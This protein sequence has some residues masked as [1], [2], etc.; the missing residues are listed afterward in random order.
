MTGTAA[1]VDSGRRMIAMTRIFL[2][3][4]IGPD[5]ITQRGFQRRLQAQSQL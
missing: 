3:P 5:E 4:E 2:T 1:K